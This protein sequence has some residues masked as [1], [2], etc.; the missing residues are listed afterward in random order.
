MRGKIV[1]AGLVLGI[2]GA[3]PSAQAQTPVPI[4][5][6]L[7]CSGIVT[8]E[9]VPHSS[10]V[11][12]GEGSNY[13]ITFDY[14]DYVYINRGGEQGVKVGDEFSVIRP[15]VDPIFIE[16]TKWQHAILRKMGTVWT[17]KGRI[18]V[19]V[20][21]RNTSIAQVVQE[22]DFLQRGDVIVPFTERPAPPMKSES[23]FDRF[24]PSTGK[25][26]AMLITGKRFQ[27]EMGTNDIAYVNLGRDQ[28]VRVGDYFRVFRYTG[29]EHDTGFQVPRTAFDV[30]GWQ[31]PTFGLGKAPGKWDW[32]N[33]PREVLGEGVVVRTG[34]NSSTV[35]LTFTLREVYAGDYVEVE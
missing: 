21:D 2:L 26:K 32:N 11:I 10:Y 6:D 14:G 22:C 27:Q 3:V 18:K 31:G 30:E 20:V 17:D 12:T 4:E 35:L 33:T 5:N 8:T 24:A 16:W 15:E 19:T 9:A 29:T 25:A 1:F 28:G 13:R 23:N 34:P 7:Y